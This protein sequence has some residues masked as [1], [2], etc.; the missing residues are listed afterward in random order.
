MKR[1]LAIF[2]LAVAVGWLWVGAALADAPTAYVRGILDKT[3]GIQG[4]TSL[5]DAARRPQVRR[6]IEQSFDFPL[7]ARDALGP[8]YERLSPGQ[9]QEFTSVFSRLFQDAYT[10]L[11]LNFL[12]KENVEYHRESREGRNARVDTTIVRPN[13][14]IPVTYLLHPAPGGWILYDVIVDGVSIL[15]N[16]RNEFTRVVRS[17]SFAYLL[18][19]MRTQARSLQ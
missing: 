14:S 3:M 12:R 17:K 16:Y 11:V 8:A 18:D 10:R 15:Q 9:R 2:S 19:K 6:I 13:E 4:D 5:T 1:P 7:M